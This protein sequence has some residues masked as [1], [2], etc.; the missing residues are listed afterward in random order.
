MDKTQNFYN[1][2]IKIVLTILDKAN[3]D[4]KNSFPTVL[5]IVDI[6]NGHKKYSR[7]TI[8]N[9]LMS[10]IKYLRDQKQDG[11]LIDEY[12]K[13]RNDLQKDINKG[14][15]QNANMKSLKNPLTYD[16]IVKFRDEQ[17]I[18]SLDHLILSLYTCMPVR[19]VNDFTQMVYIKK[20]KKGLPTDKNYYIID[21]HTF[22]YNKYK[23]AHKYG[24]YK[25]VLN[26][27]KPVEL[28]LINTINS[29][30]KNFMKEKGLKQK[31]V[32]NLPLYGEQYTDNAMSKI[33]TK[34]IKKKF[35]CNVGATEIRH[36]YLTHIYSTKLNKM[37]V[38][39]INNLAL[40]M[41]TSA[42]QSLKYRKLD[43]E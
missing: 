28:V 6:L 16:D 20:D 17:K 13:Y 22:I 8:S 29:F 10:V 11:K 12:S 5:K 18:G 23:T 40:S 32:D 36:L 19:R 24:Q 7:R 31:D 43:E 34:M 4:Y 14:D 2:N 33:I 27:S 37:S 15:S 3:I 21:S 9:Y 35:K 39:D 1:S 26:E 41:G 25:Y 38:D 42:M 30:L